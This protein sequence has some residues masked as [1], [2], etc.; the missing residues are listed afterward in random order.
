MLSPVHIGI[1]VSHRNVDVGATD[2][3][4]VKIDSVKTFP[5]NLKGGKEV[6]GYIKDIANN[7]KAN[8]LLIA[9]EATGFYDWHLLEFLSQS[10]VLVR[11][12]VS[13]AKRQASVSAAN[14]F[15]EDLPVQSQVGE[16]I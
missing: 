3:M 7:H 1:D 11:S 12:S 10:S 16:K 5:N 2:V 6:E 13:P 15:A 4:G 8:P 9:T 14:I